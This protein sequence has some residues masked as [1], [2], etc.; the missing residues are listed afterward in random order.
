MS[1]I[2]KI[3]N[4][5]INAINLKTS[6]FMEENKCK[7]YINTMKEEIRNLKMNLGQIVYESYISESD[8]SDKVNAICQEIIVKEEEIKNQKEKMDELKQEEQ[9]IL[10]GIKQNAVFCTKCGTQNENGYKFCVKCG[11][12]LIQK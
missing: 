2:Q 10:G 11:S 6:N 12:E 8:V 5:G 3:F 4:K 7:T 9:K 1:E